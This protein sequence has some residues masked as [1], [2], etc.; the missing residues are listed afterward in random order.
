MV[1]EFGVKSNEFTYTEGN[2]W[3]GVIFLSSTNKRR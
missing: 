3:H 1:R 2:K